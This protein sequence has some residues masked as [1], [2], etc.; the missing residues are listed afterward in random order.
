MSKDQTPVGCLLG[1][2]SVFFAILLW[3][4]GVLLGLLVSCSY[5]LYQGLSLAVDGRDSVPTDVDIVMLVVLVV[6]TI[7]KVTQSTI[8]VPNTKEQ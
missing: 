6:C 1:V 7:L 2:I 4:L 8:K 3:R 5:W